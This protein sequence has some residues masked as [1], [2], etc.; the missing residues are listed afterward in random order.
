M[1]YKFLCMKYSFYGLGDMKK[2]QLVNPNNLLIF[3]N[4]KRGYKISTP[5]E[6]VYIEN[7]KFYFK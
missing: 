4:S 3:L 7:G 2:K 6:H 1:T 5:D